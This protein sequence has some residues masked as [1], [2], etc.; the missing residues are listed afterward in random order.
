M[1]KI[2]LTLIFAILPLGAI[3]CG[4]DHNHNKSGK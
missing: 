4:E 1:K 3:S 2:I